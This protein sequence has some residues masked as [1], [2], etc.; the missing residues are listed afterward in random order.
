MSNVKQ[1]PGAKPVEPGDLD[2]NTVLEE[3]AKEGLTRVLAVGETVDG[4]TFCST[5]TDDAG[6]LLLDLKL[7]ERAILDMVAGYAD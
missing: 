7:T 3:A 6:A 5:S 1:F 2:P 4:R